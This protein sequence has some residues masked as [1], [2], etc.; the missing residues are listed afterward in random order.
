MIHR[1]DV[2]VGD[3]AG[4]EAGGDGGTMT[5]RGSP[6]WRSGTGAQLEV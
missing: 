4:G 3:E 1:D 6:K 5:I 2:V